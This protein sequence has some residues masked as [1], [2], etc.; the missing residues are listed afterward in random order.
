MLNQGGGTEGGER[1]SM[2]SGLILKI[3]PKYW[4]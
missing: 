3:K 4:V 1:E 2:D